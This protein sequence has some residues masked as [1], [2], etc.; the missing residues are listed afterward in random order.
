M[1]EIQ[2]YDEDQIK[3]IALRVVSTIKGNRAPR[4]QTVQQLRMK[5]AE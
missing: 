4:I 3:D 2:N 5:L 1:E